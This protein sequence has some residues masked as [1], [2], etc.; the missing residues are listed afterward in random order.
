MEEQRSELIIALRQVA[1][2]VRSEGFMASAAAMEAVLHEME[3]PP[4]SVPSDHE[5]LSKLL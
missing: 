4:V 2:Q 3:G 1:A 5:H